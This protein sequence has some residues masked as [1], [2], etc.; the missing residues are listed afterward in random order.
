MAEL[1]YALQQSEDG[2]F[3]SEVG[4]LQ[5]LCFKRSSAGDAHNSDVAAAMGCGELLVA[6][7]RRWP[8]GRDLQNHVASTLWNMS[9][10]HAARLYLREKT[11]ALQV[12]AALKAAFPKDEELIE[13]AEV[14]AR[15]I[16]NPENVVAQDPLIEECIL[17]NKCTFSVTGSKSY[18]L[19]VWYDCITCNLVSDF[20]VCQS[21]RDNCHKGHEVGS[22][23][24]TFAGCFLTL[25]PRCLHQ[26]FLAFIATV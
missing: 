3:S 2:R 16:T 11:A 10:S 9:S 14:A 13:V 22:C 26:S 12:L 19:Q 15:N 6:A 7:M 18:L 4:T 17:S 21:C 5:H 8:K 25:V 23:V 1:E 24:T 20:G